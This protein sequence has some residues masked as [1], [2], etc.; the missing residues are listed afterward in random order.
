MNGL[1]RPISNSRIATVQR[2]VGAALEWGARKAYLV[3][4]SSYTASARKSE[5][6]VSR[7]G[8][9]ELDLFE[10][11]DVLSLLQAYNEDLPPL[12]LLGRDVREAIIR[13]NGG[14]PFYRDEER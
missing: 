6:L 9:I 2:L 5:E 10:A 13:G 14:S 8:R 12:H 3:T 4:T 1:R 11:S 7:D